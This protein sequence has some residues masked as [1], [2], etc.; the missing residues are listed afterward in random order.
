MLGK[1]FHASG[2][3]NLGTKEK[4]LETHRASQSMST[5]QM[6]ILERFLQHAHKHI[7]KVLA[8]MANGIE[9]AAQKLDP[10]HVGR[11]QKA[12]NTMAAVNHGF[13][14]WVIGHLGHKWMFG[15]ICIDNLCY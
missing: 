10:C 14:G 11:E 2:L 3:K 12:G 4:Q 8:A 7:D 5:H 9:A 15:T 6:G 1:G 13:V